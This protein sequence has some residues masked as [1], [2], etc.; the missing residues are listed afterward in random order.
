MILRIALAGRMTEEMVGALKAVRGLM[1]GIAV[2]RRR[3]DEVSEAISGL[4]AK[5]R[6][7]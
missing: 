6:A 3:G 1:D 5:L 4:I 2:V 7:A